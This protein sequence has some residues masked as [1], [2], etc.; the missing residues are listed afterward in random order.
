VEIGTVTAIERSAGA[1]V[2]CVLVDE[3]ET[4]ARTTAVWLVEVTTEPTVSGTAEN[5]RAALVQTTDE[6]DAARRDRD[7]WRLLASQHLESGRGLERERNEALKRIAEL[8]TA[9]K[10]EG[11][12]F[13]STMRAFWRVEDGR[14]AATKER[15]EVAKE[16]DFWRGLAGERYERMQALEADRDALYRRAAQLV[17][18][19]RDEGDEP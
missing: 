17:E 5:L 11:E 9:I 10:A 16:R 18:L 19:L 12:A 14:D 13:N 3:A 1:T 7:F 15:A 2:Y 4:P 6:R 8:K